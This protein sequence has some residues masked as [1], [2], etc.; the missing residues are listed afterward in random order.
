MISAV[1]SVHLVFH[2]I[3]RG[4]AHQG[5][6]SL[7]A[8]QPA[9]VPAAI[10]DLGLLMNCVCLPTA[11]GLIRMGHALTAYLASSSTV[12]AIVGIRTRVRLTTEREG[13]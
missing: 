5:H 11:M 7:I 3:V 6:V 10:R 8:Y 9:G 12:L 2:L 4:C 1:W 13:V